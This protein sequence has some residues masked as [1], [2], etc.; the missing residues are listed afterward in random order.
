MLLE[1]EFRE[2]VASLLPS[3]GPN[4]PGQGLGTGL[5]PSAVSGGALGG[6]GGRGAHGH[7]AAG[8]VGGRGGGRGMSKGVGVA[9]RGANL[10][11]AAASSMFRLVGVHHSLYQLRN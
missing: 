1:K 2:R 5:G 11:I 10:N 6:G 9:G 7:L 3:T 8:G 4:A